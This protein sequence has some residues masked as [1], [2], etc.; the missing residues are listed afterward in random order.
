MFFDEDK[1]N[2]NSNKKLISLISI[3]NDQ[4][5]NNSSKKNLE[6]KR[7]SRSLLPALGKID[8]FDE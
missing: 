7:F 8:T 4:G 5:N 6:R 3:N 2:F 1:A